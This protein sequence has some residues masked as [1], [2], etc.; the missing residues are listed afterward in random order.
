MQVSLLFHWILLKHEIQHTVC[1]IQLIAPRGL[2]A[3]CSVCALKKLHC[4]LRALA[5]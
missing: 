3:V 2:L 5:L 1:R 4:L